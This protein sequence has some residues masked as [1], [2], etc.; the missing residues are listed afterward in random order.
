MSDSARKSKLVP[1]GLSFVAV[2]FGVGSNLGGLMTGM[3]DPNVVALLDLLRAL[4][5]VGLTCL[6]TG[7]VRNRRWKRWF[8]LG[9]VPHQ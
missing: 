4:F 5:L 2:S 3:T 9:N 1:I 6:V 8:E 7:I